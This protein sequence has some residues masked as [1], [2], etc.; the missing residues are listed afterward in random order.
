MANDDP[1]DLDRFVDAQ[2]EVY[3]QALKEIAAGHKHTHWMWFIFPQL[4]GLASSS[5]S[6]RYAIKSIEEAKAYLAHPVLGPRLLACAEAAVA[7]EDKT[8]REIF[9]KPDDVKLRSSATLFD[10]ASPPGSVFDRVLA[11]FF[12]GKRDERTLHLI[13]S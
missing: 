1:Y 4:D 5:T 11:K 8:A 6:K 3:D 13:A 2:R 9:G 10:A 7:V 12:E